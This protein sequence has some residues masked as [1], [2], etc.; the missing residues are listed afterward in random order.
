MSGWQPIE[1]APRNTPVLIYGKTCWGDMIVTGGRLDEYG[2]DILGCG[3][4]DCD[5]EVEPTHW[6]Y[7]DPPNDGVETR[8]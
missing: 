1:T 5:T 2:W 8:P 6:A 7:P 3:G 4:Y